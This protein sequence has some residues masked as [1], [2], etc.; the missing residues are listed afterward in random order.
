MLSKILTIDKNSSHSD[1][2]S[3]DYM[4]KTCFRHHGYSYV[5]A[6]SNKS[7]GWWEAEYDYPW[8]GRVLRIILIILIIAAVSE[9]WDLVNTSNLNIS[10]SKLE[11]EGS[12]KSNYFYTNFSYWGFYRYYRG[13]RKR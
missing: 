7:P 8:N 6:D 13:P 5:T 12:L 9:M 1:Y 11:S 3:N 10:F 2:R 4:E